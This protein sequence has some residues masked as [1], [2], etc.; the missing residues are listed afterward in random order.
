MSSE[1]EGIG[2]VAYCLIVIVLS[3]AG[4]VAAFLTRLVT[5]VDGLLLLMISL[6]MGGL[7]SLMLFL[8]ARDEGW[9]PARHKNPKG[10]AASSSTAPAKTGEGK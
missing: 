2:L 3:L 5:S 1:R 8:T 4:L 10:S 6:L 9:L 7:F